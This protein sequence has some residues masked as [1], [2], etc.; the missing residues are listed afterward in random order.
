MS[1]WSKV[2]FTPVAVV[3]LTSLPAIAD[4]P[5]VNSQLQSVRTLLS[6]VKEQEKLLAEQEQ[7]LEAAQQQQAALAD[8]LAD[9]ERRSK[10][11][12]TQNISAGFVSGR[13]FFLSSDDG[14]FLLHPWLQFQ[15]RDT[16][17]YRERI[18]PHVFDTQNGFEV[19][20]LK[21]GVDGNLFS[22]D[23]TY[24]FQFAVDRHTGNTGLE[25][26]WV[27]YRIDGTPFAL[28]AGQFKDPL[29]HEQLAASRFFPAIDR[30][31]IDDT[32]ANSEGFVKGVSA[33]YDA[34][35]FVRAEAAFT[36][37]LKN[38]NTNFQQ[39]PTNVA[40]WGAAARAEFKAFGD[41]KDYERI[42]AYGITRRSLVF[43][44]GADYTETGH[45]SALVHVADVQYQSLTGWS[46]YAAYLGRYNRGVSPKN[47]KSKLT[48]DTYDPTVRFQA[49]YALNSHW[50]PYG[51]FE[52]VHFDSRE[53]AAG[54]QTNVQIITGGFNY[55]LY[56]QAA[57][58]SF[59][60]NYLPNGSPTADDG[61]GILADN[62]HNELVGRAQLQ[63]VF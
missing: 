61:F 43:G 3:A 16:T 33:I 29:D 55:Y 13:G 4:Q 20:R 58:L 59:D 18:S 31:Y 17:S 30:T 24:M 5:E 37:G 56:G 47:S 1:R 32:F 26:A 19:R 62:R 14:N 2:P 63:V 27:K 46:L 11:L 35:K 23:L 8:T 6:Q 42:S 22:P 25:M 45:A 57:K 50:E 51:R 52:Y 15:F 39:F 60:L 54:T 53:F 41:W 40:D 12:D 36:G 44:G 9:A 21:F 7:K 48:V 10:L 28:R 34:G 38:Y 49:S